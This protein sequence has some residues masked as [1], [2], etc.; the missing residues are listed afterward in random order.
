[1]LELFEH[2]S[3]RVLDL[4]IWIKDQFAIRT[5]QI[6]HR[7]SAQPLASP[8]SLKTPMLHA[9][10]DLVQF[11]TS[12]ESFDGQHESIVEVLRMI[13]P[14]LVG[15]QGIKQG[16]DSNQVTDSFVFASK[17][18]DLEA[19][20]EP[21]MIKRHFGDQPCVILSPDGGG[22]RL[23]EVSVEDENAVFWPPPVL[24]TFAETELC[25]D[26]FGVLALRLWMRLTD[27]DHGHPVKMAGLNFEGNG[28]LIHRSPPA[29]GGAIALPW[30]SASE[31]LPA[32]L[33][34]EVSSKTSDFPVPEASDRSVWMGGGTG[35]HDESSMINRCCSHHRT[36]SNS[37]ELSIIGIFGG[38][39]TQVVCAVDP[40][41]SARDKRPRF[42]G[43]V[44]F[45]LRRT[46]P[47]RLAFCE[48]CC[49]N[50]ECF[51]PG[52]FP[53]LVP[54]SHFGLVCAVLRTAL[55]KK[56]LLSHKLRGL[57][58]TIN[59]AAE[60]DPEQKCHVALLSG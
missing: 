13:H 52:K 18:I 38:V 24:D 39:T 19:S 55:R 56:A 47:P 23:A 5:E 15:D 14:V 37:A 31:Q 4:F 32:V 29:L 57:L 33:A 35:R 3:H 11:D 54:R 9:L 60:I 41:V 8:G 20:Y 59:V 53:A 49:L 12:D 28:K 7:R 25:R 26:A 51:Q 21:D 44:N 22:S 34:G 16:A 27:V 2:L 10:L 17:P 42:P 36:N 58:S 40:E 1:M 30:R 48:C 45:I 46:P 43:L 50:W 6:P